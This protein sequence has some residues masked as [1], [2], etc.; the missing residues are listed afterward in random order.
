MEF[1]VNDYITLKLI[2]DIT[3]IYI[4]N[5][6]FRQCKK[7]LFRIPKKACEL[8]KHIDSIDQAEEIYEYSLPDNRIKITSEEEF[9]GHCSNLQAWFDNKYDTRL[10]HSNLSFPLLKKLTECGDVLAKKVFKE[11]IIKR[12]LIGYLPVIKY[13]K[14]EKYFEFLESNDKKFIISELANDKKV[15]TLDY[16]IR[17]E[18]LEVL[19]DN[20]FNS[21]IEDLRSH[22]IEFVVFREKPVYVHENTLWIYDKEIKNISELKGLQ[23]LVNLEKLSLKNKLISEIKGLEKLK[24][25]KKLNLTNNKITEIKALQNLVNLEKLIL[26][27][28]QISEIKGLEKLKNLK[29]LNLKYNKITE[30]KCLQDLVN[31]EELILEHN[32]ISEIKGL[33]KLKNLKKLNLMC[34]K[35][36]EINGL[37]NLVNL[38]ELYLYDNK[39]KEIK[40]LNHLMGLRVL[41][42]GTNK[43]SEIKNLE[44]LVNLELLDLGT[45]NISEIKGLEKL[46]NLKVLYLDYNRTISEL[47]G[48]ENLT[49]LKELRL[50]YFDKGIVN[51]LGGTYED[52][53]LE[54][55]RYPQRFVEYC[56]KKKEQE[57]EKIYYNNN[58]YL[59]ING[60][61]S[62]RRMNIS[63]I[64][65]IKNLDKIKNLKHLDLSNNI[66]SE[67][68]GLLRHTNLEYLNLESNNLSE[69]K[70][71]ET[72]VNLKTLILSNNKIIE[73]KGLE[74]LT[75]LKTLILSNNKIV[76]IKGL[77]KL[78]NLEILDISSNDF[79]LI[80]GL[81]TL[82]KLKTLFIGWNKI[83]PQTIGRLGGYKDVHR[84]EVNYPEKFVEY[85]QK[86]K[87]PK[88]ECKINDYITVKVEK[89]KKA[90]YVKDQKF[91]HEKYQ[92]ELA[93]FWTLCDYLKEWYEGDY[94]SDSYGRYFRTNLTIP[95]LKM[96]ADAGDPV[97]IKVLNKEILRNFSSGYED[98]MNFL[99]VQG[100]LDLL[101]Q[102]EIYMTLIA[103]I[104][105]RFSRRTPSIVN[106][107]EGKYQLNNFTKDSLI[108]LF[109]K[110]LLYVKDSKDLIREVEALLRKN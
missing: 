55:I 45:N 68:K 6:R 99:H 100:Y 47:K 56:R 109:R 96:L 89:R 37:Q 58:E 81:G 101:S 2:N 19:N 82:N 49:R 36:T 95:L 18:F 46:I 71:L 48:L 44:K 41:L 15:D 40:G 57:I 103:R 91:L 12:I 104:K 62:L 34:N 14:K 29:K 90:I 9:W 87:A 51:A 107:L 13:L 7:L 31:L 24:N 20:E 75:N 5:E 27:G 69:I 52:I 43:I 88:Q 38:E 39:I 60:I 94:K 17:Q 102:N 74:K 72:L 32:Q 84:N 28:N 10:L 85:S 92:V 11:E 80:Q 78:T 61:L 23:N 30:I 93:P 22:K 1:N 79:K 21:L 76:E 35:I 97:A 86:G 59:I 70:G 42:L 106:I 16:L 65:N 67:I 108:T 53:M 105:K 54:T 63:D 110:V 26:Q 83:A 3:I 73:I 25:L 33:E 64:N 66:I 98:V 50:P 8:C 4:K 77:E